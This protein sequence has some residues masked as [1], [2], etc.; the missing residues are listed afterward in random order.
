VNNKVLAQAIGVGGDN[1]F[2][3]TMLNADML[4]APGNAC[5][6]SNSSGDIDLLINTAYGIDVYAQRFLL[7]RSRGIHFQAP[8]TG[9]TAQVVKVIVQV[10]GTV[11][12]FY[13]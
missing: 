5:R 3:R 13:F 2:D 9:H 11:H 7:A 6:T 1:F 8:L 10:P 4:T 12:F